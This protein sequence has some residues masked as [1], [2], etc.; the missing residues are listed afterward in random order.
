MAVL[1]MILTILGA[2]PKLI[3]FFQYVW[4]LIQ[5]IRDPAQK[6]AFKRAARNVVMKNIIHHTTGESAMAYNAVLGTRSLH[7]GNLAADLMALHNGVWDALKTQSAQMGRE[8]LA[9][10]AS[11]VEPPTPVAAT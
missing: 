1:M 6:A 7:M 2:L 11:V 5:Q 8:A 4:G 10:A 9:P 3:E